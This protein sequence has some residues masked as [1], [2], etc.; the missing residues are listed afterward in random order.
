LITS[1]VT[2]WISLEQFARGRPFGE[3]AKPSNTAQQSKWKNGVHHL[4]KRGKWVVRVCSKYVGIF[5]TFNE[6]VAARVAAERKYGGF[7]PTHG[8]R[9][10]DDRAALYAASENVGES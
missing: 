7:S 1:T 10:P 9:R 2:G 3:S 6:A 4:R 8:K 5:P